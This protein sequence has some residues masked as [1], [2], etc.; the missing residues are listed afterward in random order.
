[1]SGPVRVLAFVA[2]GFLGLAGWNL[3]AMYMTKNV[4]LDM[5]SME[6]AGEYFTM[7]KE[8]FKSYPGKNP[9]EAM[10]RYSRDLADRKLREART[11]EERAGVAAEIFYGFW[12]TQG[13]GRAELCAEA[14]VNISP[15]RAAFERRHERQLKRAS[16]FLGD[17]KTR[18]RLYKKYRATIQS[19]LHYEMLYIKGIGIPSSIK[20]A[21]AEVLDHRDILLGKT[22]FSSVLPALNHELMS[23]VPPVAEAAE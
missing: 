4:L 11:A 12:M 5:P 22:D 1:M 9:L 2:A 21:C 20:D 14:G 17:E 23:Y 10:A 16:R 19:R 7:E 18:E 6:G 8:A 15:Y 3:F 13:R